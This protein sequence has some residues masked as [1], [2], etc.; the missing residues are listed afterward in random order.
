MATAMEVSGDF[1]REE[2]KDI[3]PQATLD[4]SSGRTAIA[5]PG[6]RLDDSDS[7]GWI[8][9]R[10]RVAQAQRSETQTSTSG[11][12]VSTVSSSPNER[13]HFAR[14]VN[15]ALSKSARMPA[16]LPREEHKVIV[17][18]RGRLHVGRIRAS[19]LMQAIT[20]ATGT[21]KDEA[22]RDTICPNVRQNIIII[23]TPDENR[24]ARYARVQTLR[25]NWQD[26]EVVAYQ[27]APE[28]TAKGVIH[29]ISKDDTLEEIRE[30]L[31][32]E[33]NP[34]C[35]THTESATRRQWWSCF[36]ASKCRGR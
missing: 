30:Y 4:R 32:N 6:E 3:T 16:S 23:S 27:A 26:Y 28:G 15:A 36:H 35:S 33:Y 8:V 5:V 12:S 11:E 14:R 31:V 29:G 7:A 17:R 22:L 13:K 19:E 24:A 10:K 25:M 2:D 1:Q 20:N 9:P 34:R 18:P 21:P